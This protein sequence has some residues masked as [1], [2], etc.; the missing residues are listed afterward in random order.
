MSTAREEM[1]KKLS[2]SVHPVPEPPDFEQQVFPPV[3]F[4]L[5]QAFKSQLEAINGKVLIFQSETEL[6]N[7]LKTLLQ[8]FQT[9]NIFCSEPEIMKDL[10]QFEIGFNKYAGAAKKMEAGITRCEY[11]VAQ[12]GSVM[13][14]SAQSGGRQMNIFPPVHI[15]I[16]TKN[17]LVATLEEAYSMIQQKYAEGLPS[18]IALVTGPSRTADIEKTLVLGAHGPRELWVMIA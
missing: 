16:A 15:V 1:L 2:T 13:V 14:S 3:V 10:V 17:Q 8:Q 6:F 4:P 12:T 11:L 9:E 18:Q 5:E 7:S